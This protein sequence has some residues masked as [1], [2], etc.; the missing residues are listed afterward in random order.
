MTTVRIVSKNPGDDGETFFVGWIVE[1]YF[2]NWLI[3]MQNEAE[4]AKQSK[5]GNRNCRQKASNRAF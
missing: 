5:S 2:K 4:E 3:K 1:V